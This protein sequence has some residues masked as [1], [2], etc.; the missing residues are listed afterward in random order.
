MPNDAKLGLLTGVLGV[1]LAA[2][3]PVKSPAA[4]GTA[5][6]TTSATSSQPSPKSAGNIAASKKTE[7]STNE[8]A[9]P[10]VLPADLG[11]TPVVRTKKDVEATTTARTQQ[12]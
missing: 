3:I 5:N 12:E 7:G 2:T 11:T 6:N 9:P 4:L 8:I 10:A 1:I